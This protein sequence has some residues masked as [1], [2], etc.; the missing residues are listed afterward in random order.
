MLFSMTLHIIS[1]RRADYSKRREAISHRSF[2]ISLKHTPG[3][4]RSGFSRLGYRGLSFRK[5]SVARLEQIG[6][7][8]V[9]NN[10]GISTGKNL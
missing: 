4:I 8:R 7:F 10:A 1:R 9:S 5:K 6:V 3:L 2:R